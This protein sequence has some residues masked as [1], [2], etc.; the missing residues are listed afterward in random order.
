MTVADVFTFGASTS[1]WFDATFNGATPVQQR[2]W[3][4]IARGGHGLL[5]APTGSGKTLAAFLSAIDYCL[6][7]GP[8]AVPGVRILYVSPLKALVYDVERNLR[9]P[10]VGIRQRAEV[11]GLS[12]R[13][14]SV[15]V[16]TGDTP[17]KERQRQAKNPADILVTTPESL[18]LLL[19]SK[20]RDNLRT[21]HTIIVDEIH[22]LAP[23]KR[24]SHL[25]VSLERLSALCPEDPQRIGLSATVRPIEDVAAFLGGGRKVD[26]VDLSQPPA[27]DLQ[28]EV[29]VPDMENVASA[30]PPSGGSILAEITA[31]GQNRDSAPERGI[32]PTIY[33]RLLQQVRDNRAT[34]IFV[35]SRGLCERLTQRLNELADEEIVRS[36]HGSVSHDQRRAIE[37]GLKQG[38]IK[39]IVATSSLELGI[40]MGAVD[41]VLLVESPGSVARG[42]QRVGRAG[43]Q[44]GERSVG[45]VYPK[46]RGDLLEC[47]VIARRMLA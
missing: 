8:D 47:A 38:Q 33:P 42:L 45:R 18:F 43:H 44:V 35:N 27:L 41:R 29:P 24:G 36:H 10:L 16:R 46:F 22:A 21:T 12:T 2:G 11:L 26:I 3:Q 28:V 1:A 14:V 39:G 13:D 9:A 4:L 37:E 23:G 15:D 30:S 19:G 34:I 20:A 31:R 6:N 17:Q 32:W 5:A 25:A 7:L 40:D